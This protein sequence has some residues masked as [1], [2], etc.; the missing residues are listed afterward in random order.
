LQ[1]DDLTERRRR[2][3]DRRGA[4]RDVD[5][6]AEGRE[7]QVEIE[8]ARLSDVH[9]DAS[10]REGEEPAVLDLDLIRADGQAYQTV[11]ASIVAALGSREAR[12][13]VVCRDGRRDD[14]AALLIDDSTR[15]AA[16]GL[17]CNRGHRAEP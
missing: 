17:L 4:G 1:I 7:R 3:L 8:R 16:G 15:D 6:F 12:S 13:R 11:L 14:H 10:A 5:A 2:G 9:L